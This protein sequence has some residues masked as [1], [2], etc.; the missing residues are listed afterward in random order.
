MHTPGLLLASGLLV[1]A[2]VVAGSAVSCET[3]IARSP[4]SSTTGSSV[5]TTSAEA[6]VAA[7][8]NTASMTNHQA[9]P[10]QNDASDVCTLT[11]PFEN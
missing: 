3:S 11:S 5:V 7:P 10:F 6:A 4:F 2:I 8:K 1:G 9:A